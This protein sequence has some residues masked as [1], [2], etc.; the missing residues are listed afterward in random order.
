MIYANSDSYGVSGTT[1]IRYP[2]ALGELLNT[3]VINRGEN[4]SCNRRIIRTTVRDL[5]EMQNDVTLAVICLAPL[6]RGEWW[7]EDKVPTDNDGHFESFQIH[8]PR[9]S[10][11]PCRPFAESWYRLYNDEAEQTNLFLEILLFKNW[12]KSRN[13][14]YLIFS[15]NN[16][17]IK[18][19]DPE[20]VFLRSFYHDI[21]EDAGVLDLYDFSFCKFCLDQG[22]IPYDHEQY[23]GHG[24]HA[25]AAH[26]DF[27]QHL[28]GCYERRY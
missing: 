26:R 3:S 24:H 22:H 16:A 20:D 21:R 25:E 18:K 2:E 12:L 14:P 10:D 6:T 28:L 5:C 8:S 7:N 15:G 11:S 19:I 27:A 4:G 1:A 17:T 13:I 9:L 23:G